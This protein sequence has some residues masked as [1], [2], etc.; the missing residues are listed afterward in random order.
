MY[1]NDCGNNFIAELDMDLDGDHI[2]ECP[3]CGHEHCR[4]IEN[5]KVTNDRWES[6]NANKRNRIE[7]SKRCVWKSDSQ[8]IQTSKASHFIREA[9]LSKLD[10]DL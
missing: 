10:M 5:G 6:R 8:P 2:V 7:V 4:T 9:W 3:H 1:C